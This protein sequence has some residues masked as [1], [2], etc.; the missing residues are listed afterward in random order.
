MLANV[1]VDRAVWALDKELTYAVPP[2]L[3]ERARVG[4]VV[5]VALR[6]RRVRGWVVQLG[7]TDR[8]PEGIMP[9]AALSGRGPVF[10]AALLK[11]ARVLARSYV[12]PLSSFLSLFT[13]ERLGRPVTPR[14][15]PSWIK[16]AGGKEFLRLAPW[17]DPLERYTER[18]QSELGAGRGAIVAVPEV[19]EGS[20]V[21]ERLAER[22]PDQAAVVHS[23][24]GPADRSRALWEV[25]EGRR[26]LVLGGR[27]AVF[28]PAFPAGLI[29]LHQEHDPSFKHQQAPY[30]DARVAAVERARATGAGVLF[31]SQAPSPNPEY[32]SGDW[33]MTE[34]DRRD[35]RAAWPAVEIIDPNRRG[36][37]E[38]VIALLL[39]AFRMGR[40]SIV[41]L[42]RTEAT[43]TGPGPEE[44]A[45]RVAKVVPAAKITRAD[46]P[47]LGDPGAL[48]A[49]LHGDVVIA[50][51]AALTEVERPA[52]GLV[53]ALDVDVYLGRPKG[54]AAEDAFVSLWTL[55]GLVA[56]G[57]SNGR[58]AIETRMPEHHAVQAVVRGDYRFFLRKE[59]EARREAG[60]PPFLTLVRL[61]TPR[62]VTGG[63]IEQLESLPGTRVLGPAEGGRLG[64]ELLLKVEDLETILDP[65]G[66]MVSAASRRILVEVDPKD[67]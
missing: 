62:P 47:G 2:P 10:D 1:I 6:G 5:R 13:P 59:L 48:R 29:V 41:L 36:L 8:I 67:W 25:A 44:V 58:V 22:F 14:E 7:E 16:P 51:E 53:I 50:S 21:L 52:V 43:P 17:E 38:R 15:A 11:M 46:R 30:Y 24:V 55:A 27:G 39:E 35:E 66:T 34:P 49:A 32:W 37:P 9:I 42:P 56:G 26:R 31:S 20:R 23:G 65:L 64:A 3:A 33:K 19:R 63:L 18:I 40:R 45:A 12:Q 61:Q 28:A 54:R 60:A 4:S 57:D